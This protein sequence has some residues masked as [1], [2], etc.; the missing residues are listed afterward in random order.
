MSKIRHGDKLLP[1]QA[2]FRNLYTGGAP[3][4]EALS[5]LAA[6]FA[7]EFSPVRFQ[8]RLPTNVAF[9]E[10][11]TPPTQLAL[12]NFLIR[13]TG[14]KSA[15][16]IGT[17][18]GHSAMQIARM[19]GPGGRVTTIEVGRE[20]AAIARE[21]FNRNGFADSIRLIEGSATD[22]LATLPP[23]SFDLV[24]VDGSKQDYLEYAIAS[25]KLIGPRGVI[26]VD[27]VFFHGDALNDRPG[28]EKGVGCKRLLD[29]YRGSATMSRVLLPVSN[30]ILILFPASP[31]A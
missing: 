8:M 28:T 21:N 31:A 11:S 2:Y 27:D 4:E 18:I 20:F 15:L 10:M 3:Y 6:S 17:F 24:F 12:L 13:L 16:E 14:A 19:L 5:S 9:E 26:V 7:D 25:E 23:R 29:H 1:N 30:G 22:V